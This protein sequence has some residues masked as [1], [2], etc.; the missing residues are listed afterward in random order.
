MSG[1]SI[2]GS[3]GSSDTGA[4]GGGGR[5]DI[6]RYD[7]GARMALKENEEWAN[8]LQILILSRED[9]IQTINVM[10]F[11]AL[12]PPQP[13]GS[14]D[15]FITSLT[16]ERERLENEIRIIEEEIEYLRR[17]EYPFNEESYW[18]IHDAIA[19]QSYGIP[20]IRRAFAKFVH[21]VWGG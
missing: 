5:Y 11:I 10:I 20:G 16:N 19:E 12:R 21:F 9:Q 14:E 3:I 7:G 17:V 13:I 15:K 8:A 1:H 18:N 2:G 6:P 4:R